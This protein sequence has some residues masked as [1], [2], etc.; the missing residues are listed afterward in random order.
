MKEKTLVISDGN[1]ANNGFKKWP[2]YLQLLLSKTTTVINRSV[3][4]A[5]NELI[6]MQLAETLATESIDHCV[7]QWTVPARFDLVANNFW[8]KQAIQDPV[9]FFNLVQNNKKQWWVTSNSQNKH[10]K[11]YHNRYVNKWQA[12]QRSQ[13]YIIAAAELLKFHNVDFVFSLCYNLEFLDP[14][15]KILESYPWAWHQNNHG[16][17]E[18]R[19][20]SKF[21]KY[22]LGLSQ[23]HTL[24][25]LEW[26]D[27][28]LK[29]NCTFVKYSND[30]YNN[31][32]QS[33][34]KL[35]LK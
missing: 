16:L 18:F 21:K 14:N 27:T 22:D 8:R 2:F 24:I 10:I 19:S 23:P 12:L 6:F 7:I 25:Q 4:G 28:V 35:C 15:K 29:P 17:S 31:I 1:G 11:T 13:A 34:I 30:V 3:I 33:L 9:Y 20:V 32:E 26:I 5:S